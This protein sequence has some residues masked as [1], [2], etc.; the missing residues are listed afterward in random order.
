LLP[1]LR[2]AITSLLSSAGFRRIVFPLANVQEL[3]KQAQLTIRTL[4]QKE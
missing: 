1:Y 4:E 3:A 2:A